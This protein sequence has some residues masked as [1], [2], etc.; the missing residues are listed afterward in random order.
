MHLTCGMCIASRMELPGPYEEA[1]TT[2][3]SALQQLMSLDD[4]RVN[5]IKEKIT[6]IEYAMSSLDNR[7]IYEDQRITEIAQIMTMETRAMEEKVGEMQQQMSKHAERVTSIE[8][9]VREMQQQMTRHCE[10]VARDYTQLV[11]MVLR[12]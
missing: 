3:M 2:R 7:I 9:Q 1:S 12:G 8:E 5:S 11:N 4:E 6:D 10:Q